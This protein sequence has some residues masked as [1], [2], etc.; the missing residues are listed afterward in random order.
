MHLLTK[1]KE[2]NTRTKGKFAV[3]IDI[4]Y[5]TKLARKSFTYALN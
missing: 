5:V 3:A 2:R 4:N 1:H